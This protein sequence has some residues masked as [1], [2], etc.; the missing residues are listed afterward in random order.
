M[1]AIGTLK[2]AV[3][4][5]RIRITQIGGERLE[6]DVMLR[7]FRSTFANNDVEIDLPDIEQQLSEAELLDII[8]QYDGVIAGD[9]P[10]TAR[11]LEKG[12]RLKTLARWGVGVDA[13]DQAYGAQFSFLRPLSFFPKS[14][15]DTSHSG[16]CT[17]F[18]K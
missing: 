14:T 8:N 17:V 12:T 5:I 18:F 7:V 11:V 10:F 9:D 2:I 6:I 3:G 15:G 1:V 16:G 13:V 4:N